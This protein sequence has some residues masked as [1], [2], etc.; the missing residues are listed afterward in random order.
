MDDI[1]TYFMQVPPVTRYFC[2]ITFFFSFCMTYQIISPYSLF[3]VF[4]YVGKG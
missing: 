4:E 1:K 3:L 2:T